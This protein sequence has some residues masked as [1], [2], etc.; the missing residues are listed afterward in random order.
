[1]YCTLRSATCILCRHVPAG[2]ISFV[3]RCEFRKEITRKDLCRA[4]GYM[5]QSES[6]FFVCRPTH[7]V[8]WPFFSFSLFSRDSDPGSLSRGSS[9]FSLRYML[10]IVYRENISACSS[11]VD[12]R[13]IP[14]PT[15]WRRSRS[16]PLYF[17]TERGSNRGPNASII[18]G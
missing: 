17:C 15:L 2:R 10:H 13:L 3:H 4:K 11:L 8:S 1:M 9:P 5:Q 16:V 6:A 12:S 7:L 18:L 14:K